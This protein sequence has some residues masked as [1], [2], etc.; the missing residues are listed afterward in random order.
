MKKSGHVLMT[1]E[2]GEEYGIKDIGGKIVI[3]E[4]HPSKIPY[5]MSIFHKF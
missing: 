4:L 2:L 3:S 1:A 5:S